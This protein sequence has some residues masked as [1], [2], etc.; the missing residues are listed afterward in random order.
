[1]LE[2]AIFWIMSQLNG[3]KTIIGWVGFKI[4]EYYPNFP[5]ASFEE[6]AI[7]GFITLGGVGVID[8]VKKLTDAIAK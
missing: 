2:K 7:W 5:T 6:L 3:W 4:A 1:M 8:K